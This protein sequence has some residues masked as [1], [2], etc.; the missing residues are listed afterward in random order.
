MIPYLVVKRERALQLLELSNNPKYVGG[1]W[2]GETLDSIKPTSGNY[3][4]DKVT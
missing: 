4:I 1:G 2:A 3:R